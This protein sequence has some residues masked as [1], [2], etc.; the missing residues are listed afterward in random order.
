MLLFFLIQIWFETAM[1]VVKLRNI[2][3]HKM[4]TTSKTASKIKAASKMKTTSKMKMTWRMKM[5][6]KMKT[7]WFWR[8]CLVWSCTTLVVLIGTSGVR[9]MGKQKELNTYPIFDILPIH[10]NNGVSRY[11]S[12]QKNF[13]L[14]ENFQNNYC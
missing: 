5:T 9:R 8:L 10:A 11:P 1:I 2:W 14:A 13:L 3:A 12:Y 7:T 6:S 4:K